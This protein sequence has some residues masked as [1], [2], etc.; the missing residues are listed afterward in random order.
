MSNNND[1]II[2]EILESIKE[3]LYSWGFKKV[4]VGGKYNYEYKGHYCI[5]NYLHTLGFFVKRAHNYNDA[6]KNF[7]ED[8]DCYALSL[9]KTQILEEIET[10]LIKDVL[11][12]DSW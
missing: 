5:P 9:G 4:M 3:M 2:Q 11:G 12:R 8:G 6:M 1:K 10:E 7:H